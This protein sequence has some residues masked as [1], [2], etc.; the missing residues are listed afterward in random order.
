M[1]KVND[2]FNRPEGQAFD[3]TNGIDVVDFFNTGLAGP[4]NQIENELGTFEDLDLSSRV[5]VETATT[6]QLVAR[7][8][9]QANESFISAT[10]EP[11]DSFGFQDTAPSIIGEAEDV[12][13]T[14]SGGNFIGS[15]DILS[16]PQSEN[17]VSRP[18]S[19]ETEDLPNT[20]EFK[21]G[22]NVRVLDKTRDQLQS[23]KS[24]PGSRIFSQDFNDDGTDKQVS[25]IEIVVPADA[26]KEELAKAK[27]WVQRTHAAYKK[28]G[29]NVPIRRGDGIK[30]GGR[31]VKGFF[32][33]EDH[34][35]DDVKARNA[36]K[37]NPEIFAE[38]TAS[39][40]GT[41]SGSTF[42][43]PHKSNDPGAI[44]SDGLG[45]R[46]FSKKFRTP[47]LTKALQKA[48]KS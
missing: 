26:T 16:P 10:D 43:N 24:V 35:L 29:V 19:R 13:T 18:P 38:I 37:K 3:L 15:P 25:G 27:A 11:N 20:P 36:I 30:R 31:G 7:E 47:F 8:E 1:L 44:G 2:I 22:N 9:R 21:S 40:L 42:I 4:I 46:D 41:I 12:T 17:N 32:H 45:E 23:R 34:F 28:L 33:L 6:E 5:G 14:T 39:T 48:N